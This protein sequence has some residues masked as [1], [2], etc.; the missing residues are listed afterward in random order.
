[1]KEDKSGFAADPVQPLLQSSDTN[2]RPV[3]LQFG[4]DGSL[5]V[6]DWFNPLVGHMQHN[7]RDPNRDKNHGRIWR[8]RYKKNDLVKPT[9]IAV[10]T[11]AELLDALKVYEYRTRYRA[12]RELAARPSKEVI[13]ATKKWL[14]SLKPM[15]KATGHHQL[16]ALWVMQ[17][18]NMVNQYFLKEL[19]AHKDYRI[20]AAATRVLCYT[21]HQMAEDKCLEFLLK[22]AGDDHARVRLEAV[23]AASFFSGQKARDVADETLLFDQDD[24]LKYTYKETIRTL[25]HKDKLNK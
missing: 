9:K 7:L 2:F 17:S 8:I 16:E 20:R 14:A 1:M 21:R 11:N 4:P 5:Y 24:Y 23:R 25:D 3:D 15:D 13:D 18:H 19:L 10:A 6:L 22:Q 12:R